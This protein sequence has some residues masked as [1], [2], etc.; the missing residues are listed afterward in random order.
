MRIRALAIAGCC[1]TLTGPA[2]QSACDSLNSA[3]WLL[4]EWV[5][6]DGD[7]TFTERWKKLSETTFE[8]DGVTTKGS[9][10]QPIGGE[11]MRLVQMGKGVFYVSKVAHN[12]LPVA[13]ELT[14][15]ESKKLVFENAAHDFPTRVEYLATG[16]D[17]L[18]V[19]VTDGG[20]KGF[21]LNFERT[22]Q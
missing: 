2:A 4:G 5:S 1:I 9:D 8:G 6:R 10:P 3:Q 17:T 13:F 14:Q 22:K 7:K 18:K 11:T 21:T 20:Q 15:C 12:P 16:A 19:S